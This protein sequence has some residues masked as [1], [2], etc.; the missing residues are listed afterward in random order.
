MAK[1]TEWA[2][3]C[4]NAQWFTVASR[5][6]VLGDLQDLT[7]N[8]GGDTTG[9]LR[10]LQTT[11]HITLSIW[12][13]FALFQGNGCCKTVPVGLDQADKLEDDLLPSHD[14]GGTPCWE[15]LLGR[16]DGGAE[17][18]ISALGHTGDEVVCSRVIQVD[19]LRS[20]G[21]NEFVIE[22][23]CSVNGVGNSLVGGRVFSS[24]ASRGGGCGGE[25]SGGGMEPTGC[26]QGRRDR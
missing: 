1:L 10:H 24:G 7:G 21:G 17:L 25:L 23:I 18:L 6:H 12:E 16:F 22:K 26:R 19:P 15:G 8:L 2:N 5:L 20:L 11:E 4:N 14:A 9:G 13:S 3:C